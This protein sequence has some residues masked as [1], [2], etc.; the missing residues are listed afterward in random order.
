MVTHSTFESER[1][2]RVAWRAANLLLDAA[3]HF[4]TA[5]SVAMAP[6]VSLRLFAVASVAARFACIFE[7]VVVRVQATHGAKSFEGL[8][9]LYSSCMTGLGVPQAARRY[10]T[11]GKR[12]CGSVCDILANSSTYT[13]TRIHEDG[14]T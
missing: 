7:L 9:P 3:S 13:D 2:K 4:L 14:P 10:R 6:R 11:K 8:S 1:V 12:Q 5:S